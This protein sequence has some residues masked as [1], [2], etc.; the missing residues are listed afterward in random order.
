MCAPTG[1]GKSSG[2]WSTSRGESMAGRVATARP[3]KP[4]ER[5]DCVSVRGHPRDCPGHPAAIHMHAKSLS[6]SLARDPRR[7]APHGHPCARV[8]AAPSDRDRLVRHR[9]REPRV[10][11][12]PRPRALR[13][14]AASLRRAGASRLH[15]VRRV[16]GGL[17]S[18]PLRRVWPRSAGDEWLGSLRGAALLRLPSSAKSATLSYTLESKYLRMSISMT[19]PPAILFAGADVVSR[20]ARCVCRLTVSTHDDRLGWSHPPTHGE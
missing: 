18:L 11:P 7:A 5:P 2:R 13:R 8:P 15:G 9:P 14:R 6:G 16:F 20:S 19:Q 4:L 1:S 12:R 3:A 10:L 17:H